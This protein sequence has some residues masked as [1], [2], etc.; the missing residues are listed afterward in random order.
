MALE[1]KINKGLWFVGSDFQL[2]FNVTQEDLITPADM[3]GWTLAFY[4]RQKTTDGTLK[5]TKTTTSGIQI[6]N[7]A[8]VNT[9]ANVSIARADTLGWE[10][11]NYYFSLWRTDN[12]NDVPLSYGSVYMTKVAAQP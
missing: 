3:T 6:V 2:R 8:G 12:P 7:G 5:L 10:E 4:V 9:R 1:S 11:G